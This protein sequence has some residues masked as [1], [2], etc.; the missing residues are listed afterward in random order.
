[1]INNLSIITPD[2][3]EMGIP[4]LSTPEGQAAIEEHLEGVQL[5]ILDNLSSLCRKGKEN[6]AESWLPVQEWLLNLRKR[7]I[8]VLMVHH[9][10]K[11]GAQRGTSKREDL[12]DTVITMKRPHDYDASQGA[13]F[14]VY[15]EKSRGFFGDDARPFEAQLMGDDWVVKELEDSLLGRVQELKAGGLTQR[16]IAAEVGCSPAKVNRLLKQKETKKEPNI[17]GNEV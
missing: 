13:R 11:T 4:D 9:A 7:G 16:E 12:L 14:E 10:G 6:E 17:Y 5:L 8:S 2:M 3:Q 15:Y 1:M